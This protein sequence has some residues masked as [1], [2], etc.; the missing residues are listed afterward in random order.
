MRCSI[1]YYSKTGHTAEMA[2]EIE[3]GIKQEVPDM[4]VGLFTVDDAD[5]EFVN[6]SQAVLFGTPTYLANTCWQMKKWFD[7]STPKFQLGGKIGAAFATAHYAQGG[8]DTA[9]L[10][11]I[12]HMMVKGM[13]VYS[14]GAALGQ[15][16]IHLGALAIDDNYEQSRALFR[17]FGQRIAAKVQE[18]FA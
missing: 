5:P 17:I 4:E 1:I 10:T 9:I 18:L 7:E 14:G 15:P 11:L 12:N 8:A 13:L 16:Y 2:R 6:S 3:A